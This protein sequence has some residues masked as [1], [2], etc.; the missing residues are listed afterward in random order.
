MT[1]KHSRHTVILLAFGL[2]LAS[3]AQEKRPSADEIWLAGRQTVTV[4][5]FEARG[6]ILDIGGGGEGVIGQLKGTQVIAI[7]INKRELE[8]APPGPLVK[9]VM[10]ARD[11][12]FL[13]GAFETAT[14]F[15]TFMYIQSTDHEQVF[16]EIFRVLKPGGRLLVWD[17]VFPKIEDARKKSALF[18]FTFKLPGRTVNTGYGA[19]IPPREQ[20][21]P[22]F[23]ELAQKTGFAVVAKETAQSWFFLELA[24]PAAK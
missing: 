10:D 11:L 4:G 18:W 24:K 23:E 15:F 16:R 7:D 20:G 2:T 3:A 12:K 22:H 5:N 14:V 6:P 19:R 9:I 8:D 17:V 13:D 21:L 1:M